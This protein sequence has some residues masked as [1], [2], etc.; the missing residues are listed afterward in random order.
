MLPNISIMISK[1][2]LT[3]ARCK[4]RSSAPDFSDLHGFLWDNIFAL[5]LIV[6]AFMAHGKNRFTENSKRYCCHEH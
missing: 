3:C 4:M 6:C 1:R 5:I 2:S